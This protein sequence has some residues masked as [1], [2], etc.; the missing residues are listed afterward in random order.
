MSG[1]LVGLIAGVGFV[2]IVSSW[3]V[4]R[5]PRD[6]HR[7]R[8][9][10]VEKGGAVAAWSAAAAAV[11]GLSAL[12]VTA[13]PAAAAIAAVVGAV[14]PVSLRRRRAAARQRAVRQAWPDA[15]DHLLACVRA[16]L[17]LPEAVAD[18]GRNGP[19]PLRPQF[20]R[21]ADDF[22]VTGAFAPSLDALQD[23]LADPVGDR[24][25]AALRVAREV[26]G[27]DLGRLLSTLSA[28]LREQDRIRGEI[29]GR[30]GWTVTAARLAVSAPWL[31]LA[32]LC[33]RPEAVTA[34]ASP[35]GAVVLVLVAGA[36][37]LAYATMRRVSRL[38]IDGRLAR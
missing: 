37:A 17:A 18:V 9:R 33:T 3:A 2:L 12:I 22:R 38:P 36:S 1:A 30:Q 32:L 6:G 8:R 29:E 24:V 26:G 14:G 28:M 35:A 25:C 11:A 15:V 23:R 7:R 16:G 4:P 5:R 34:Y 13:V 10:P 19:E 31:T 27:T 20:A 21:F